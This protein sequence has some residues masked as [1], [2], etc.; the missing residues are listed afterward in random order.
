M[1]W[2][3]LIQSCKILSELELTFDLWGLP[4]T[5]YFGLAYH[6]LCELADFKF[7]QYSFNRICQNYLALFADSQSVSFFFTLSTYCSRV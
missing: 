7:D 4:P 1:E 5:E 6:K 2:K 3:E